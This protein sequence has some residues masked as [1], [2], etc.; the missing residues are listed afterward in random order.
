MTSPWCPV[1]RA[2][3]PPLATMRHARLATYASANS[4]THDPRPRH[5]RQ[6]LVQRP[7]RRRARSSG[8]AG[9]AR[10]RAS[11]S[12]RCSTASRAA[13]SR[14]RASTR[15]RSSRRTSR[16]RTSCARCSAA[17]DGAFELIDF[18][19]RFNLYDRFFKPSMLVRILR[20]LSGEPRARVRCRPTYEYG[21][22][23]DRLAGG[24]RTT[25]STPG[26][27][28]PVRLTTNVPLTYVEDERP[29]LLER[30]RHLVLTWGEPLEAGLEETAERF[31]ERTLD[32]WRRWV[33]G[34]RV[35]RDYQREVDPLGARAQAPPVRGHGRAARRDDDEPARA[36]RLR[37][38]LGL[39]LLLAARRVLH[40]Q[41]AR[42]ARP[43]GGDGALPRVPAQPR[44]RSARACSSPRTGSTA[45]RTPRSASSTHLAGFNGR[46]AGADRQPGVRA[47]PE[48]RLRRDGARGQP[49]LPRRALRRRGAAAHGGRDGPGPRSTRST[50]GSR[51]R[52]RA[53]GSSAA[54]R[55]CTASRVLMHWA[56]AR[57]AA[58]VARCARG[59]RAR[60]AR[61]RGR[62]AR[63]RS[64]RDAVL[65]RRDRRAHAGR[66]RA[67]A[68]RRV[69]ARRPSRV[70]RAGRSAR[71]P[72]R[73]RDPR[74]P[75]R[76][77]AGSC[78]ATP[79][80]TTSATWRPRSRSARS[81]SSRRSRSS[82]AR[83]RR[84]R[85]STAC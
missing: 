79:C 47:R 62:G 15:P 40:A 42:A 7:P 14:S 11:C 4:V 20:P 12:V 48:R 29:F 43:L 2:S 64:S 73:R 23:G 31:L 10:T 59:S 74:R 17:T 50:H 72:A 55:G 57:R 70:L 16:T 34:T 33:K 71:R 52:T 3:G 46:R 19:P 81:G 9:R 53:S 21:L 6:L 80:R 18:A 76:S 77:T 26:F 82:A 84:A 83:T 41:R 37:P 85:S 39:P 32:Y 49:A 27:P 22:A 60:G 69:A 5:H 63:A 65:E 24:R 36:P 35:P 28:T 75:C 51:S 13:R 44:A 30:D 1:C 56:G 38:Q 61:P 67:A 68:R 78:A 8:C 25:S 54:R 66:R 45:T 58:E